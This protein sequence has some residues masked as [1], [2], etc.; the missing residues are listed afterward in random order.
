[1][2]TDRRDYQKRAWVFQ[3]VVDYLRRHRGGVRLDQVQDEQLSPVVVRR[4]V[5]RLALRGLARVTEQGWVPHPMLL[6]GPG[7]RSGAAA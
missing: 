7:E 6:Q 2:V 3:R 5:Q 1:M 4:I